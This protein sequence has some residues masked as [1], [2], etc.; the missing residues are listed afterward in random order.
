MTVGSGVGVGVAVCLVLVELLTGLVVVVVLDSLVLLVLDSF[1]LF[2][3]DEV[4]TTLV[5]SVAI[6]VKIV[7]FKVKVAT[8]VG[9]IADKAPCAKR[10][11]VRSPF[12]PPRRILC[13]GMCG[14]SQMGNRCASP[15]PFMPDQ[16]PP[17]D[18]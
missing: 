1:V 8:L 12:S 11:A 17:K 3:V 9:A 2:V 10:M 16:R 6:T 13:K 14:K 4:G 7:G 15:H 5:I 18:L